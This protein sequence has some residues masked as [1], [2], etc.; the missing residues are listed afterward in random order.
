MYLAELGRRGWLHRTRW[1]Y[2]GA[3]AQ[4]R[5]A[6]RRSSLTGACF[7]LQVQLV[8]FLSEFHRCGDCSADA[9]PQ[10]RIF[11]L[12]IRVIRNSIRKA[13]ARWSRDLYG[14]R[15]EDSRTSGHSGC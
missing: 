12:Q 4:K 14:L 6:D 1:K 10:K 2:A 7:G 3:K 5:G 13:K 9:V 11:G 8:R 15:A